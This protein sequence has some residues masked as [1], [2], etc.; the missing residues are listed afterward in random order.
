VA[1]QNL[2]SAADRH[3][4]A[5]C[6]AEVRCMVTLDLDFANPLVFPPADCSGIAVLRPPKKASRED[7]LGL[8]RTLVGGL[9]RRE[10]KGKLWIVQ[11]GRIREHQSGE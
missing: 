6:R 10:I 4:L 9:G 1:A 7:L 5:V 3:L 8:V 2:C 11:P